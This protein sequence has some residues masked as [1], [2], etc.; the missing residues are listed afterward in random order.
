[1]AK[2]KG[3]VDDELKG[4]IEALQKVINGKGPVSTVPR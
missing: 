4:R 1:M 2:L 3:K